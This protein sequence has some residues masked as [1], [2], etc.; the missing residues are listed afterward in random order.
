VRLARRHSTSIPRA[1]ASCTGC[2]SGHR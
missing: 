1:P 2:R